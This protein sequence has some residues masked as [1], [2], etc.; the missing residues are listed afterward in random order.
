MEKI[1]LI[2]NPPRVYYHYYPFFLSKLTKEGKVPKRGQ[3]LRGKANTTHTSFCLQKKAKQTAIASTTATM[4]P[5]LIDLDAHTCPRSNAGTARLQS[6]LQEEQDAD[7]AS[8][9]TN[10]LCSH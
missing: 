5:T 9:T 10:V 4:W 7:D 6:G 3:T 1:L 8:K 2:H